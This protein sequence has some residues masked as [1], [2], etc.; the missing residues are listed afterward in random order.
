MEAHGRNG[1]GYHVAVSRVALLYSNIKTFAQ[2][3]SLV[4]ALECRWGY[5]PTTCN[6]YRDSQWFDIKYSVWNCCLT[7]FNSSFLITDASIG[8][9]FA[10][11]C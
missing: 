5:R 9:H 2:R 3:K 8:N 6:L 10:I 7:Q 1:V 4:R 11:L